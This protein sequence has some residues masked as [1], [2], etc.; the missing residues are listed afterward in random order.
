[1]KSKFIHLPNG[2]FIRLSTILAVRLRDAHEDYN[3][4]PGVIVDYGALRQLHIVSPS[5]SIVDCATIQERDA[6][7][8][9]I[10]EQLQ[11]ENETP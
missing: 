4:S 3:I 5:I 8:A 11:S 10:I 2:D 9:S 1:M 6:L 7:A